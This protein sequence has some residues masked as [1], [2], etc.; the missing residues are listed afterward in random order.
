MLSRIATALIMV[1][2]LLAIPFQASARTCIIS[3]APINQACKPGCCANKACCATS[4]KKKAPV[5]FAK[6]VSRAELNAACIRSAI[7]ISP[8]CFS[9]PRQ[10]SV[11]GA[12]SVALASPQLAVL[13]TFLI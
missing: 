3:D 7:A 8:V 13:C 5:P 2:A 12:R 6:S 4:R 9:L 1:A 10:S 11:S